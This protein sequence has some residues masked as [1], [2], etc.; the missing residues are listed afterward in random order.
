MR[1]LVTIIIL[2]NTVCLYAGSISDTIVECVYKASEKYKVPSELI[3]AI[4]DVE[5]GFHPY[6]LNVAGK[7]M[8]FK[9]E[10]KAIKKIKELS[11][12]KKSFDVGLMQVNRWW[13]ER[14]G[15]SY[16]LGLDICFNI[17]FGTYI[18]AYEISRNGFSWYAV[19][20]YHSK[21]KERKQEYALK[22]W[23]KVKRLK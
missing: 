23:N 11:I 20:E 4:I 13:F 5:S 10:E 22:V 7:P 9:S 21:R 3:L 17:H 1:V 14:L 18:L 8:F 16:Q 19:G 6:A 2:F 15:Y 12:S